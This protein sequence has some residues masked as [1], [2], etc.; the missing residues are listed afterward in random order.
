[1]RTDGRDEANCRALRNFANA[2]KMYHIED[3]DGVVYH[4][5]LMYDRYF[6]VFTI[7]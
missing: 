7:D 4:I 2:P 3:V 5:P 6:R 1:M